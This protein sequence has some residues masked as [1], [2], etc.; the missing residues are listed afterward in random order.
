MAEL[1]ETIEQILLETLDHA[2]VPASLEYDDTSDIAAHYVNIITPDAR[3]FLGR[4]GGA[5]YALE[6][7]IRQFV[8][9]KSGEH[10]RIFLDMNG[11]RMRSVEDLKEEAKQSAKKVRLYRKDMPL[12]PMSSFERRIVHM[13][14]AEYPDIATESTGEGE[15]RRVVIKPYP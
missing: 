12:R 1:K 14:L 2:G 13:V 3:L 15:H 7:I 10:P 4:D 6:H 11:M 8:E 5:L 9:K